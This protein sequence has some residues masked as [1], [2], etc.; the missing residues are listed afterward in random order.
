MGKR[1][2]Q[3]RRE[4]DFCALNAEAWRQALN[5]RRPGRSPYVHQREV[6]RILRELRRYKN[7][8]RRMHRELTA[9]VNNEDGPDV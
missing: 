3:V 8:C 1:A 6:A 2:L 4:Y 5:R 9:Y 7:A